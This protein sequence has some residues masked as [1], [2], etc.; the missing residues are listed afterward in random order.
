MWDREVRG[1]GHTERRIRPETQGGE[2]GAEDRV[3]RKREVEE[4]EV[5]EE[6]Q[7]KRK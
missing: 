1:R 7:M 5:R 2:R 4:R 3:R 6:G